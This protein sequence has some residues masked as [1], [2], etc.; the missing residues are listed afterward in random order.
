MRNRLREDRLAHTFDRM[1]D[2]LAQPQ[3]VRGQLPPTSPT[4]CA[5]AL[6]GPPRTCGTWLLGPARTNLERVRIVGNLAG[7]E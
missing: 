3:Q 7:P 2:E 5:P 6:S 1:A 4:R